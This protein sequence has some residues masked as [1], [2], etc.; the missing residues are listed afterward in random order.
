MSHPL[1]NPYAS[2]NQSSTQGQYGL[3]RIQADR[4]PRMASRLRP[5]SSFGSS[6][7]SSATPANSGGMFSA[8]LGHRQ[9]DVE[10]GSSSM[11]W[12]SKF[13]SSS[14]LSNS[15]SGGN[16]RFN[17]YTYTSESAT[18]IL[19]HFGLEKE[20]LEHLISIPEDQITPDN[21]PLILHQIR[22]QKAKKTTTAVQPKPYPEPQPTRSMSGMDSHSLSSSGGAGMRQKEMSSAY[23]QPS[24]VIGGVG[25]EN[26]KT[27]GSRNNSGGSG[28]MLLMDTY[29]SSSHNREPLQ[30]NM[31]EVQ[32]SAL[33]PSRDQ[34]SPVTSLSSSYSS[35]LSSVA[36]PSNDPTKRLQTQPNQTSQTILSSLSLP[37][38]DTDI[39]VL[40]SEASKSVP[41]K[42]PE[43][44]RQSPAIGSNDAS[45]TKNQSII[46]GQ[47]S[48]VA[49]QMK[50]QQPMQQT[51]QQQKQQTHEQT[52]KQPM[53]Q[54]HEQMQKQPMQQTH[55]QPVSQTGQVSN[56]LQMATTM[57][58]YAADSNKE[59]THMKDWISHQNTS[60]HLENCKLFRKQS[61]SH[62]PRYDR[63]S[64]SCYRS[65]SRS[66]ERRSG[67][68]RPSPRR[69]RERRSS[70]RRSRER[71]SSPKR[72]RERR[73]STEVSSPQRK[74]SRR[75]EMLNGAVQ[76]LSQQ[77]DLDAVVKTLAPALLAELLKM[78]V[79]SS[80]SS[81]SSSKEG[82]QS[83]L[84]ALVK[85]LVPALQD[86]L[87]R[88]NAVSS[89]SSSS[90][91]SS[92]PSVGRKRLSSAASSS[93]SSSA[94]KE[95]TSKPSKAKPSL[96][97]SEANSSTKMKYP[98]GRQA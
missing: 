24:K 22:I 91:S 68:R 59:C 44:D 96:Q 72:S 55:E 46:Q 49:E 38:K 65:S 82:K 48:M 25:E 94:D 1:Y 23:L 30:K 97:K 58:D 29:D 39:R 33:G 69:S 10:N 31:M 54:T 12:S 80:S 93:S 15:A 78:K 95:L 66:P 70:P 87:V 8:S 27:S 36:P 67:K 11:D 3:P 86:E 20:D 4:D 53:Q 5:G 79:T 75:R 28:S 16:S 52:Q 84:Q 64:F 89:S 77:S 88:M 51:Q 74:K 98:R 57:H 40:K 43:A 37:K 85:A 7:G 50:K 61:R 90:S 21:L 42:E 60:L 56:G 81:S 18:N 63:P 19:L 34:A 9:L 47:G 6:G 17:A 26:G 32:S 92:P 2:G 73:S 76:S 14:A 62:S 45:G 83:A 35:V 41:L 13:D 71:R